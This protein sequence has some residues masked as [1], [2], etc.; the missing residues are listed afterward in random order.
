MNEHHSTN[1]LEPTPPASENSLWQSLIRPSA[2]HLPRWIGQLLLLLLPTVGALVSYAFIPGRDSLLEGRIKPF[3]FWSMVVFAAVLLGYFLYQLLRRKGTPALLHVV[4][5][6]FC[7]AWMLLSVLIHAADFYL[8]AEDPML[9][10]CG[11]ISIPVFYSMI[12]L[13]QW[14]LSR[15]GSS[16]KGGLIPLVG[17]PLVWYLLVNTVMLSASGTIAVIVLL[18]TITATYFFIFLLFYMLYLIGKTHAR[19]WRVL[20]FLL[21][22]ILPILCFMVTQMG[23]AFNFFWDYTSYLY[24]LL[25]IANGVLLLLP[26][27]RKKTLRLL[28]FFGRS[29]MYLIV[30][31][32]FVVIAPFYSLSLVGLLLAGLGLLVLTPLFLW[33]YQTKAMFASAK[34]L[35]KDCGKWQTIASSV[36][37]IAVVPLVMTGAFLLERQNLD[38]AIRHMNSLNDPSW[39]SVRVDGDM[40]LGS[41]R[42]IQSDQ[43]MRVPDYGSFVSGYY[44][45]YGDK[46]RVPPPFITSFHNKVVGADA[47]LE[48]IAQ[49]E[50]LYGDLVKLYVNTSPEIYLVEDYSV[51]YNDPYDNLVPD[52][53]ESDD[54]DEELPPVRLDD[55]VVQTRQEQDYYRSFIHLTLTDTRDDEAEDDSLIEYRT[56]VALPEGVF[57]SDYYLD[58]LGNR[59]QGLLV[60][61]TSANW[62]YN[63][64]TS[65]FLDPGLVQ[66]TSD[67]ISLNVFPFS[68]QETRYTGI[69][70]LHR[71]PVTLMFDGKAVE[72]AP[73]AQALTQPVEGENLLFISEQAK[74]ALN[75]ADRE[76]Y[77]LFVVDCSYQSDVDM[78]AIRLEEFVSGQQIPLAQANV[79]AVNFNRQTWEMDGEW[80]NILLQFP[81]EGGFAYGLM[82][83]QLFREVDQSRYY[84][85]LIVLKSPG[86][87][88]IAP[89]NSSY[90]MQCSPETAGYFTIG[91]ESLYYHA[92]D[93]SSR[94]VTEGLPEAR[95][96]KVL[97]MNGSRLYFAA[98]S[99]SEIFYFDTYGSVV[100][101]LTGNV[102]TDALNFAGDT[103]RIERISDHESQFA[104][105]L[106]VLKK[107]FAAHVMS[108]YSS[109]IVLE[110]QE[111]EQAMF[112]RQEMLMQAASWDDFYEASQNISFT[113]DA[114]GEYD[115]ENPAASEPGLLLCITLLTPIAILYRRKRRLRC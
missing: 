19:L 107:S 45:Y 1:S 5:P 32:F 88:S 76:P 34:S 17:T 66:Y 68:P 63:V 67:G 57:V 41:L 108:P 69:E 21:V 16:L 26:E 85:V 12:S 87:Q 56:N 13:V 44:S 115:E 58:V 105:M 95:P 103:F 81:R 78:L 33:S 30:T 59:K 62:I 50:Q 27:P 72:L 83:D 113:E 110:T 91:E 79:S 22:F 64:V 39:Q 111:Q 40:L 75:S 106:D 99:G 114:Q 54:E 37:G 101:T 98:D 94:E 48:M 89:R 55:I 70:F 4:V 47:F 10:V 8:Q 71:E 2:F 65:R 3:L 73:E 20:R 15:S 93:G 36:V 23:E 90:L 53:W 97:D 49:N 82:T 92:Y 29:A 109:F 46:A 9:F 11:L 61:T 42:Y 86:S 96:V 51:Y 60:E 74:E 102:W 52:E 25:V 14:L 84:P 38:T 35:W 24:Y 28:L 77:Y 80:K 112:R 104:A 7:I 43:R 100:S 6:L 18:L 31:Y